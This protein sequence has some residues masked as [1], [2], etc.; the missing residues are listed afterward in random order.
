MK[1]WKITTCLVALVAVSMAIGGVLG[2][3]YARKVAQRKS[4]PATWHEQA[5]RGLDRRLKLSPEQKRQAQAHVDDAVKELRV[6]HRDTITRASAII[7]NLITKVDGDL[8][9][10]QREVFKTMRPKESDMTLDL[11]KVD[12]AKK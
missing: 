6:V 11:L 12:P 10:E 9:P 7:S 5:M 4:D 2:F 8:T 1:H 3:R